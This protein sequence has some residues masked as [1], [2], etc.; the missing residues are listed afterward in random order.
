[1]CS[2]LHSSVLPCTIL[3][4]FLTSWMEILDQSF[5]QFSGVGDPLVAVQISEC[6]VVNSASLRAVEIWKYVT[7]VRISCLGVFPCSIHFFRVFFISLH[8]LRDNPQLPMLN[9]IVTPVGVLD[10]YRDEF[11]SNIRFLWIYFFP[12]LN[13]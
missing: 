7:S 13:D 1:M 8:S 5:D 10:T 11:C 9:N 2:C 6:I 4:W 3:I 12:L